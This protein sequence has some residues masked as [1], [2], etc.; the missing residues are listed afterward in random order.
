MPIQSIFSISGPAYPEKAAKISACGLVIRRRPGA[1]VMRLLCRFGL[2]VRFRPRTGV[3]TL[4][5]FVALDQFDQRHR[6]VVA[7]AEAGLD[8]A[9]I[10]ARTVGI[11]FRQC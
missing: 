2:V 1:P 7:V 8:D 9:R 11:A 10:A 4:G 5:G 6:G 3:L